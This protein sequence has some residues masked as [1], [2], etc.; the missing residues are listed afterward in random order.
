MITGD[1][2]TLYK[3]LKGGCSQVVDQSLFKQQA[4]E[5]DEKASSCAK[6]GIARVLKKNYSPKG[7]S[8]IATGFPGN[9]L[10]PHPWRYLK[11]L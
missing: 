7:W 1:L 6:R 3:S 2:L 9:W 10:G 5:Q 8:G 11:D 4:R